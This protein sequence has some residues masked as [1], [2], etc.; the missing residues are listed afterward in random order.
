[1]DSKQTKIDM[2]SISGHKPTRPWDRRP[3]PAP[4][5]T[6]CPLPR[7]GHQNAD[8]APAPRTP[9]IVGLASPAIRACQPGHENTEVKRLR[10]KPRPASRPGAPRLRHR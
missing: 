4:Q 1:M 8:A 2:L 3:L 10:D 9:P 7:G 6:R 5:H